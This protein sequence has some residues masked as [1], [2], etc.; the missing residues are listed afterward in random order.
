MSK[1]LPRRTFLKSLGGVAVGLPVLEIMLNRNGDAFAASGPPFPKRFAIFFDGQSL[2]SD[3][4]AVEFVTPATPGR[5]YAL[6]AGLQALGRHNVKD[7]VSVVSSMMI[8]VSSGVA[9]RVPEFHSTSHYPMITG[10]S[11]YLDGNGRARPGSGPGA[12][13]LVAQAV[14]A[15]T[16]MPTLN[17]QAQPIWYLTD[18][19]T[20]SNRDILTFRRSST[21]AIQNVVNQTSPQAAFRALF[22]LFTPI[23]PEEQAELN[24]RKSILD[25]V[26]GEYQSLLNLLGA[27]D[28]QRM[29]R[30]FDEIRDLERRLDG[31]LQSTGGCTQVPDPGPD[32]A[33]GASY[34]NEERRAKIFCDLIHMAWVC[35]ITRAA[36]LLITSPQSHMGVNTFLPGVGVDQHELGHSG[37]GIDT[38]GPSMAM[39]RMIDWHVDHYAYLIN[40][41]KSTPEGT[42]NVLDNSALVFMWE[43]GQGRVFGEAG[44]TFG[45]H[46]TD[47][48]LMLLAG[49]AGGLVPQGH[50]V[51]QDVHPGRV[52]LSAMRAV[53]YTGNLGELT[54]DIPVLFGR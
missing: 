54:Q 45:S 16:R 10:V 42:G 7:D 41:L 13:W 22:S 21:G 46:S 39:A 12:D 33:I 24:R 2:G 52:T 53:G 37:N 50:V 20:F 30:H 3:S 38:G 23:T 35:D 25:L 8:P 6:T 4:Q 18:G 28:R 1:I 27:N 11:G 9:H 43:G 5:A 44:K 49:R 17:Y 14:G 15:G 32:P 48:M 40:K 26:M 29:S 47:N 19:S 31:T 51:Q 34:S 36:T